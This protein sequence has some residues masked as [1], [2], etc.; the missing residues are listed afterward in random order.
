MAISELAR[1]AGS[2]KTS[3]GAGESRRSQHMKTSYV[4]RVLVAAEMWMVY[5]TLIHMDVEVS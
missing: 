4:D 1:K 3:H 5:D 2:S